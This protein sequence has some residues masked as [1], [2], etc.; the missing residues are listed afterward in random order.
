MRFLL[1]CTALVVLILLGTAWSGEEDNYEAERAA[2]QEQGQRLLEQGALDYQRLKQSLTRI[3]SE[4]AALSAA[5]GSLQAM[6]Q[7]A[8]KARALDASIT[9]LQKARTRIED[10]RSQLRRGRFDA[11]SQ[12]F[13]EAAARWAEVHQRIVSHIGEAPGA[14]T[15]PPAA[16]RTPASVP[17]GRGNPSGELFALRQEIQAMRT[18][19]QALRTEVVELKALIQALAR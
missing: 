3:E 1:P 10:A 13:N 15:M 4:K 14:P 16:N 9:E 17:A 2:L 6:D 5:G 7:L 8:R 18:E 11:A 12:A 19:L